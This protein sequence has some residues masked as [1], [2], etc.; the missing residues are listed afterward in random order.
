MTQSP[1]IWFVYRAPGE[2]PLAKRVRRLP[3]VSVLAFFQAL[4]EEA[5]T[6]DTP[7]SVGAEALGGEVLGFGTLMEA[8]REHSLHT[9]KSTQALTKLLREHLP[10]EGGAESIQVDSHSVRV[11]TESDDVHRAYFFLDEA[12]VE[13]SARQLAWLLHDTATLPDGESDAP[14]APPG[15]PHVVAPRGAGEGATYLVL[16]AAYDHPALPGTAHRIDGVRLP[17][18]AEYLRSTNADESGA[19]LA[20]W[21]LEL[22]ALRALLHDG[23]TTLGAALHRVAA[24]PLDAIK[25]DTRAGIGTH[26]HAA[27]ELTAATKGAPARDAKQSIV[28]EGPHAV[29]FS[30]PAA[31]GGHRPWILF[32]DRWAA[33]N[34]S[35]AISLLHYGQ[36]ADPCAPPDK[37]AAK[38]AAEK[39]E[40]AASEK[41]ARKKSSRSKADPPG[42]KEEKAW[43]LIV[44]DRDP[45]TATPYKPST[46][47]RGGELVTHT[48]FG[49]GV[50]SRV[51]PTKCEVVFKDGPRVLVQGA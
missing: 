14:F 37:P 42:S 6:S 26:A 7:G 2:G 50:V 9:P 39:A 8:A 17:E 51:E 4:I 35:L 5:R 15:N 31:E 43:K 27:E 45:E 23:E 21:P 41:P 3:H 47:L 10:S 25:G 33:A 29:L 19:P 49:V 34:T 44:G 18:L 40:A 22:R 24:L 48:K 16:P 30:E 38:T 12:A 32:D 36:K 1:G 20:A 28:H 13:R 46:R 11:F